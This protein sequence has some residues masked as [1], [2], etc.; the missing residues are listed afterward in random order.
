MSSAVISC[1]TSLSVLP[2]PMKWQAGSPDLFALLSPQLFPVLVFL[3][4]SYMYA[5][6]SRVTDL[7]VSRAPPELSEAKAGLV[8][9]ATLLMLLMLLRS[10]RTAREV[11]VGG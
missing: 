6:R 7:G 11:V 1:N 2:V 5:Y 3:Y 10:V 8:A 9:L 4:A